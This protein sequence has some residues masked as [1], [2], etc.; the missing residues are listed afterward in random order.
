MGN[1]REVVPN[2]TLADIIVRVAQRIKY[3]GKGS[4]EPEV[5]FEIVVYKPLVLT[6]TPLVLLLKNPSQHLVRLL[7]MSL[8]G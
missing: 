5:A 4:F 1:H 6:V 8:C 2:S 3:L 7:R